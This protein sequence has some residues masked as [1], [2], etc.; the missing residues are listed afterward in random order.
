MEHAYNRKSIRNLKG[1]V[2]NYAA[3]NVYFKFSL[4]LRKSLLHRDSLSY[5]VIHQT[6]Y[7][8]F[9]RSLKRYM[10][11]NHLHGLRFCISCYRQGLINMGEVLKYANELRRWHSSD[12]VCEHL[13]LHNVTFYYAFVD[14]FTAAYFEA[15]NSP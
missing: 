2:D 4:S 14:I 11:F 6:N 1:V 15:E 12:F 3:F 9:C 10:Q 5:M 13:D 8:T 7:Q